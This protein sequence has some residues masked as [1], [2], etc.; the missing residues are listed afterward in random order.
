[1]LILCLLHSISQKVDI[2][3]Y[4]LSSVL[5][6]NVYFLCYGRIL[7]GLDLDCES[8]VVTPRNWTPTFEWLYGKVYSKEGTSKRQGNVYYNEIG[9]RAQIILTILGLIV[10]T[11]ERAYVITFE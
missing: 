5:A 3:L 8:H 4:Q 6:F 10:Y 1:M 9:L 7:K 2:Y 11:I